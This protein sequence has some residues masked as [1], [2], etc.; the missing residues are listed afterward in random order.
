MKAFSFLSAL[1]LTISSFAQTSI[2]TAQEQLVSALNRHCLELTQQLYKPGTNL[3]CS[4]YSLSAAL[5][6]TYAGASGITAT[7]ME[8]VMHYPQGLTHE[9][10]LM[11]SKRM[12]EINAKGKVKL[13]VANA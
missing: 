13:A 9:G 12:V 1:L 7:E 6:M 11:M 10:F 8:K 2:Q 4:P 5:A 3:F